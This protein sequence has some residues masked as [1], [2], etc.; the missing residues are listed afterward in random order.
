MLQRIENRYQTY[1][2]CGVIGSTVGSTGR[3]SIPLSFANNKVISVE[4][5]LRLGESVKFEDG[6]A[7]LR[8][9]E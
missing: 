4:W 7:V 6:V 3:G 8:F 1:R 9:K 2:G 5:C